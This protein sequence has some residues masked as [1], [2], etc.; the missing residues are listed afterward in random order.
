MGST[1]SSSGANTIHNPAFLSTLT[2]VEDC[3]LYVVWRD[4][5]QNLYEEYKVFTSANRSV[6][7]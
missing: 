6:Q 4:S 7:E 1:G 2:R 3:T 5:H